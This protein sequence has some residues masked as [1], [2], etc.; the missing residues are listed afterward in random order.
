MGKQSAQWT[1]MS[2]K[3][4]TYHRVKS[5]KRGGESFDDLLG[6]L[7]DECGHEKQRRH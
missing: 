1:S 7:A 3:K 6:R 2:V 5:L 4:S